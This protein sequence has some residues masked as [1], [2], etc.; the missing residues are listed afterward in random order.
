MIR[1]IQQV[2]RGGVVCTL[3]LGSI[4]LGGTRAADPADSYPELNLIPWPQ[5]VRLGEGRMRLTAASRIIVGQEELAH[6]AKVLSGEITLLT[7]LKLEIAAGPDRPG[8]IVLKIDRAIQSAEP[9]LAVQKRQIVWTHGG[10][11]RLTVGARALVEG[12]DYRA[13]CEGSSTLLQAIGQSAGQVSLPKLTIHDW[14]HADYCA[15]MVDVGRQDHPIH[16]LKKMVEV[17]RFY[18]VRYLQLHL[19]DDQGWTFPSTKY[20][21]LGSKNYGAHGGVAPKVYTLDELNGLVAYADARGVTLVPEVEMP[22][23]SGAALRSL[24]HIFDAINPSTK[25]PVGMGCM[26]MANEELYPVLDTIIGEVCDVFRS[27]PYFHIGGDEVSMGRVALHSG[28]KAFMDKHRLKDDADLGRHFIVQVNELVKKHGRKTIKWE[29]L[30]NEASKDSI[31]MAWDKN[32]QTAGQLIAKGFATITCPWDL[33]VPWEDWNMYICNGSRL[34]KGDLVLGATL[35]AWEQPPAFHLTGVRNVASRQERTWNPEH[36]VTMAGFA[37][38]FQALDAAVNKLI[39]TPIQLKREAAFTT[40]VGTR[41]LLTAEFAFDGNDATFYRS[42]KA[43]AKGD[44]FII[45]LKQPTLVHTVEVLTG[46]NKKGLLDGG[47][48]QVSEDG[49]A[50]KTVATLKNGS[51]KAVLSD[52]RVRAVRLLTA[53]Q[54]ADPL[55]VREVKLR[56]M[57]EVAG[58]VKDPATAI[59][60]GNVAVLKGDTS[61]THPLN[62]CPTPVINKGFT[63]ALNSGGGNPSSYSGPISGAGKVEIHMGPHGGPFKDS[64]LVLNGKASNTIKGSWFIKTGRLVLA[65]E[66]GAQALGGEIIVGGQGDNDGI[67]WNNSDQVADSASIRLRNSARGGAFLDLNGHSETVASLIMDDQTRILT[68][69]PA[70]SGALTVGTLMVAGKNLSKGIYTASSNWL[71]GGGYV[72]VGSVKSV[73]VAGD[74]DDPHQAVGVGNLAVLKAASNIKLPAGE[75]S[76]PVNIGVFPL[77]LS[78]VNGAARYGGFITGAGTL[79]I[80]ARQPLE[81]TD[82]SPNSYRG[83]TVLRRGV[84]KLSKP[85]GA[86]AIPGNLELGGST[87]HNKGDTVILGGDGQLSPKAV[88]TLAGTQPS[89]LDLAGHK[90][91]IARANLSRA[92]TIRT[93]EGGSLNAKQLYIDGKRLADGAYQAPQ[94]WLRGSGTVTV[95]ARVNVKGRIGD[96]NTHVGVGNIANLT[97][98]TAFC[99]PVGDC[100]L[101][102]ITNGHTLTLDSGNGNPLISSGAISGTGDVVLLMGPTYTDY[103]DAP[104]RLTGTKPNTTTGKFHVR[105]GRVQLEKPAGVDAISGDVIVGGQGFNDCLFW[106]R[107][108]QIKDSVHITLIGAGNNG[109]AY[110]HLNG[111]DETVAGLTMTAG[112]TI[113]TDST[114]GVGGVLTVRTLTIDGTRM[115]AGEYNAAKAKWIEGKGKVV[116]QR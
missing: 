16:W 56:L 43:P 70:G 15:M 62:D 83:L 34:K 53:S 14:P 85:G 58:V 98:D 50:F 3:I 73:K 45:T 103:K 65:K 19:T 80:D 22:G 101:D 72:I 111:C 36:A 42:A 69:G 33:G 23:H 97:G 12:F 49:T 66:T 10:A 104:L 89:F 26:N 57:V 18:K 76:I 37:S 9:I 81:I 116:V 59:G 94:P 92:G 46:I 8:D 112:N 88:V 109:F 82:A 110:L 68:D 28:Y 7:G 17:C 91:T 84:L 102:I 78:A 41:D 63:L 20:P 95:D 87:A 115:P 99:Y 24:P 108:D 30:A 75:C 100:G 107:N 79:H 35:V 55:V 114:A 105:K 47:Q 11:H 44:H 90:V 54:Q 67:V 106:M 48:V 60:E 13:V 21:Q 31:V 96:C 51:A 4:W 38:R 61:F 25:Q 71:R 32:N 39:G 52:H 40:S 27:S 29:G 6:L 93:G 2:L 77:T 64:P 5:T 113:K 1:P 74:I 86:L